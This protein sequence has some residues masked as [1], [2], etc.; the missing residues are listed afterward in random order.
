MLTRKKQVLIIILTVLI[1][2]IISTVIILYVTWHRQQRLAVDTLPDNENIYMADLVEDFLNL[3]RDKQT[4]IFIETIWGSSTV[5]DILTTRRVTSTPWSNVA[6]EGITVATRRELEAFT[7]VVFDITPEV[8][9]GASEYFVSIDSGV[10]VD[11]K[12]VPHIYSNVVFQYPQAMAGNWDFMRIIGFRNGQYFEREY[13][14]G[15]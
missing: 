7:Y 10:F 9:I 4:D 13:D 11:L 5:D 2:F 1:A 8:V 14:F 3:P 12:S 15:I 6:V